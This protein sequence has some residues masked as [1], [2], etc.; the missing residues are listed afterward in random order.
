MRRKRKIILFDSWTKGSVHIFRLLQP[1]NDVNAEIILVHL[2][3]WGDEPGRPIRENI[4]GL[5]TR[6]IRYYGD[7]TKVLEDEKPDLVF[8]LSL[9]VLAHR[10]FNRY[11]ISKSIPTVNLYHGVHSVF[12]SLSSSNS[13]IMKYWTY[14]FNRILQSLGYIFFQYL[15]CL[16]KTRAPLSAWRELFQDTIQ[17]FSGKSIEHASQDSITDYVCVFNEF[18]REHAMKKYSLPKEK[19]SIVGSP[20]ILKFDGLE[21]RIG[22]YNNKQKDIEKK[23]VYIGTGIRSTNMRVADDNVYFHHLLKTYHEFKKL[24][25]EIVFKLHYSRNKKMMEL[26]QNKGEEP[27]FCDNERFLETLENSDG[28]IVEPSTAALIPAFIGKPLFLAKYGALEGLKFGKLTESYPKTFSLKDYESFSNCINWGIKI[29]NPEEVDRWISAATG[30]L[31]A[32][33]MPRRVVATFQKAMN[34]TETY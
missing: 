23:L 22:A 8:F 12:H 9:D 15:I 17:K 25:V 28:A 30:P 11:C 6:D 5:E 1:L 24:D 34:M 29:Y 31:P 21:D 19:I 10:I 4:S 32:S 7:L 16:V 26:F 33:E 13:H 18:D 14:I 2:G 20:D 27:Y 3:S